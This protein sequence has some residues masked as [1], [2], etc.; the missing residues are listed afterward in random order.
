[1]EE[2]SWSRGK[3]IVGEITLKLY[4]FLVRM[5][6]TE[7]NCRTSYHWNCRFDHLYLVCDIK[8]FQIIEM[9]QFCRK[10]PKVHNIL[11]QFCNHFAHNSSSIQDYRYFY[12]NFYCNIFSVQR[13][14]KVFVEAQNITH[15]HAQLHERLKILKVVAETCPRQ[16]SN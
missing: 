4:L 9:K 6:Y 13:E 2:F 7:R 5:N 8:S 12:W 3:N 11:K 1:M 14:M 10:K 15:T 16:I